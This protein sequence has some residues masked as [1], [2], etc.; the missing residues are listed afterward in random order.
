V[1]Q[2]GSKLKVEAAREG[3]SIKLAAKTAR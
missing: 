2:A 3:R 1:T